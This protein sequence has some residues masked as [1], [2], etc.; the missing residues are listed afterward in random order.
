MKRV[1]FLFAIFLTLISISSGCKKKGED[2][3]GRITPPVSNEVILITAFTV[4]PLEGKAPLTVKV[5][6]IGKI[7]GEEYRS[8]TDLAYYVDFNGDGKWDYTGSEC[9]NVSYTYKL[10]GEYNLRALIK[11]KKTGTVATPPEKVIKVTSNKPPVIDSFYVSPREGS[12][13]NGKLS[14]MLYLSAHDPD[15]EIEKVEYDMNGDGVVDYVKNRPSNLNLS[16]AYTSPGE[17]SIIVK[18]Y[19]DS[20]ASVTGRTKVRVYVSP[21]MVSR[22]MDLDSFAYSVLVTGPFYDRNILPPEFQGIGLGKYYLLFLGESYG[23][24]DVFYMNNPE[25]PGSIYFLKRFRVPLSYTERGGAVSMF[26]RDRCLIV[27]GGGGESGEPYTTLSVSFKNGITS[28]VVK[29]TNL[30]TN[31]QGSFNY[32]GHSGIGFYNGRSFVYASWFSARNVVGALNISNFS[33]PD[34]VEKSSGLFDVVKQVKVCPFNVQ[35]I[36][37]SRI[38]DSLYFKKHFFI[39]ADKYGLVI[40]SMKDILTKCPQGSRCYA[41]KDSSIC[42]AGYSCFQPRFITV[43]PYDSYRGPPFM[44]YWIA[45]SLF[46]L[47]G[48]QVEDEPLYFNYSDKYHSYIARIQYVAHV[49]S[50]EDFILYRNG[51]EVP[52]EYWHLID[53]KRVAVDPL[54]YLR[55]PWAYYTASYKKADLLF[56]GINAS[57][58]YPPDHHSVPLFIIDVTEPDRPLFL[59]GN[60]LNKPVS[61]PSSCRVKEYKDYLGSVDR[62]FIDPIRVAWPIAYTFSGNE[63]RFLNVSDP[64]QPA[65]PDINWHSDNRIFVA[66]TDNWT[67]AGPISD[68]YSTNG[69]CP[70]NDF[71]DMQDFSDMKYASN[72]YRGLSVIDSSYNIRREINIGGIPFAFQSFK[73]FGKNYVFAAKGYGGVDLID[74]TD[75]SHPEVVSH[76]DIDGEATG[77]YFDRSRSHLYI[78]SNNYGVY[79]Y[80]FRNFRKPVFLNQWGPDKKIKK[81]SGDNSNFVFFCDDSNTSPRLY[82]QRLGAEMNPSIVG[83]YSYCMRQDAP[84]YVARDNSNLITISGSILSYTLSAPP[85]VTFLSGEAANSSVVDNYIQRDLLI[86]ATS[87][88]IFLYN[89]S[90]P[91][92]PY[93]LSKIDINDYLNQQEQTQGAVIKSIDKTAQYLFVSLGSIGLFVFDISNY[94]HPE[95]VA[96]NKGFSPTVIDTFVSPDPQHPGN[97]FYYSIIGSGEYSV[98]GHKIYFVKFEGLAPPIR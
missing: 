29:D 19:D 87:K 43:G 36:F 32:H 98:T 64:Y 1:T 3:D 37:C 35:D 66:E 65:T 39:A 46:L 54:F 79:E 31:A 72:Y 17:F 42:P 16:W 67:D 27:S 73:S 86:T 10:P 70:A 6:L 5:T 52:R 93:L 28:P 18:I 40:V 68:C 8:F 62:L 59:N 22:Y 69:K 45:D 83:G 4:D 58:N 71:T 97:F 63:L 57:E 76:I 89:I 7:A 11:D 74:I 92:Q 49:T 23:N 13:S 94:E 77:L 56:V 20:G 44:S 75:I 61:D 33:I 91:S 41:V 21:V 78:A 90:D 84:I 53:E 85:V 26:Y 2:N 82:Y 34:C 38:L 47:K 96:D 80:D 95:I 25:D 60:C 15:G 51:I 30:F 9:L 81:L 55:D 88:T 12:L 14:V 50:P 48:G 24:I